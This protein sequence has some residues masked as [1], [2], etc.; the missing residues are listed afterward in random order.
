VS[1]SNTEQAVET[2][3]LYSTGIPVAGLLPKPPPAHLG[4][5]LSDRPVLKSFLKI[6]NI[7]IDLIIK[8]KFKKFISNYFYWG[9]YKI[10]PYLFGVS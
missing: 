1:C 3:A 6:P 5:W 2:G 4:T 7:R 9:N 10:V 8:I